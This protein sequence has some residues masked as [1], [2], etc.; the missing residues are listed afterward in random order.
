MTTLAW[1]R[2]RTGIP[3]PKVFAF[4]DSNNNAIGFKWIL[5]ELMSGSQLHQKWRTLLMEQKVDITQR[6]A[7]IQA[8]LFGY[9]KPDPAFRGI[10]TLHTDTTRETG[11]GLI[12]AFVIPGQLVSLEFFIGDRFHHNV[13]RGPFHSSHAWLD[14]QLRIIILE[15]TAAMN[16]A[17]DDDDKEDA[18]EI[19]ESAR[20]LL[21]LLP[22]VFFNDEETEEHPEP[23]VLWHDDLNMHNILVDEKGGI[24]AIVDWEC[25]SA[26]PLWITTNMPKFLKGNNRPEKPRRDDYSDVTPA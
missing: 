21:S 14:S 5:M 1:L 13:P 25:V 11:A 15:Q 6:I 19:L 16:E 9:G 8:E 18:E 3:V 12:T 4:D 22:K 20:P 24:T 2:Q 17:E 7:H 23:T 26:L 10:G